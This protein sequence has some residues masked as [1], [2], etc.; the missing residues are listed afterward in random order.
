MKNTSSKTRQLP[1]FLPISFQSAAARTVIVLILIRVQQAGT[2]K[3]FKTPYT[4][5][6]TFYLCQVEA[7]AQ[8]LKRRLSHTKV[9][10]L[11]W[12][13]PKPPTQQSILCNTIFRP[14]RITTF[15][16]RVW[17]VRNFCRTYRKISDKIC[18]KRMMAAKKR[19]IKASSLDSL[20]R[21]PI[22]LFMIVVV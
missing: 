17:I 14:H 20:S 10:R 7:T 3:F 15:H 22:I 2:K 13:F 5:L 1:T 21:L 4:T 12:V 6:M 18:R 19:Q 16:S 9:A 11:V 8:T